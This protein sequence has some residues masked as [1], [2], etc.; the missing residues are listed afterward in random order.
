M[1]NNIENI[2]RQII[3][4]QLNIS[5]KE[6]TP[7]TSFADDLGIDSLDA[8]QIVMALEEEFNINIPV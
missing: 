6:I 4:Q 5:I 1:Q 7:D 2:I 8:I 3:V